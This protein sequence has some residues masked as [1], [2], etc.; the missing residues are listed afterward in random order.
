MDAGTAE[1]ARVHCTP[2]CRG[3]EG[4][5]AG[6]ARIVRGRFEDAPASL[7]AADRESGTRRAL[8][9]SKEPSAARYART[10]RIGRRDR[11][12]CRR[13]RRPVVDGMPDPCFAIDSVATP[14]APQRSEPS[15]DADPSRIELQ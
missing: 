9:A 6:A 11:M 1:P 12:R 7:P 8:V 4:M 5:R 13:E 10:R 14:T 3:R 2:R 15:S